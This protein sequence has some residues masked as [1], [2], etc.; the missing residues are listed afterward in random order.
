MTSRFLTLAAILMILFGGSSIAQTTEPAGV[1]PASEAAAAPATDEAGEAPAT[2]TAV[3]E[4]NDEAAVRALDRV[5]S[6]HPREVRQVVGLDPS[7]LTNQE[8]LSRYP[9]LA[10]VVAEYPQ[11]S[12]NPRIFLSRAG[13]HGNQPPRQASAGEAVAEMIAIM[14]TVLIITFGVIWLIR[15][16][17]EQRRWSRLAR[18][19]TEVHTKLLDRFSQSEDLLRYIQSPAGSRFLES[20]PIQ[21]STE[22]RGAL[23][24]SGTTMLWSLQI[25]IIIA[26]GSLGIVLMSWAF[27]EGAT[28]AMAL[29]VIGLFIGI[30]FAASGI[31][32]SILSKKFGLLPSEPASRPAGE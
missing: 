10:A 16:V 13:Y 32:S 2:G 8:Y 18:V 19:Q 12:R 6:T 29:G 1:E 26:A 28:D 27:G 23:V 24:S 31:V 15:T 11:L 17:I 20:A 5:L 7:L 22:P 9:E 4:P 30:G 14:G 25:G 21:V 3:R